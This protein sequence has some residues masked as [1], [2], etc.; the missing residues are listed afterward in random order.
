EAAAAEDAEAKRLKDMGEKFKNDT[1]LGSVLDRVRKLMAGR[2][3][4]E[5]K[6]VQSLSRRCVLV[7]DTLSEVRD[8]ADTMEYIG[9]QLDSEGL[10]EKLVESLPEASRFD[11]PE[12][13]DTFLALLQARLPEKNIQLAEELLS[14]GVLDWAVR[15]NE[16]EFAYRL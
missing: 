8:Q 3:S 1:A 6:D 4:F 7:L 2:E 10:T 12:H 15:D 5:P 11:T 9:R 16:A 14:Y 13:T